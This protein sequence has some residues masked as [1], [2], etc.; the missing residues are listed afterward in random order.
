M[1]KE[2]VKTLFELKL[3]VIDTLIDFLPA[4]Y[5][6]VIRDS[7][8]DLLNIIKTSIEE[9]QSGVKTENKN[10]EFKKISIE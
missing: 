9:K 7:K 8:N 3:D 4:T 10:S 5:G 6:K 2:L 1:N